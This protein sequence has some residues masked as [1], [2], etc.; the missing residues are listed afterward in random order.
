MAKKQ[1]RDLVENIIKALL[2]S[3]IPEIQAQAKKLAEQIK[4]LEEHSQK[5][6]EYI[7]QLESLASEEANALVESR[8]NELLAN[9]DSALAELRKRSKKV[10][11]PVAGVKA[12]ATVEESVRPVLSGELESDYKE[13]DTVLPRPA[14]SVE[15]YV[16]P[17][18]FVIR[19]TRR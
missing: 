19:K 6:Q 3:E 11:P 10:A 1:R 13:E 2:D 16:T 15:K 12:G 14:I 8:I 4:R 17:E 18:G 7:A 5:L 9:L